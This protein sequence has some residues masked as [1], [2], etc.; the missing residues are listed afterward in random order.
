[1][2]MKEDIVT[3]DVSVNSTKR[4]PIVL[5]LDISPSMKINNRSQ[6]LNKAVGVLL[7]ELEKDKK[8][9][10][11]AEIAVVTFSTDVT[12]TSRFEPINYW[13]GK[14]FTPLEHGGTNLSSAVLKSIELIENRL[15][16]L[17]GHE[18][19][20]Y[21]PFIVLVTD[22]DPC[23]TDIPANQEKSINAVWQHCVGS[24]LIAPYIIGVGEQVNEAL[25]DRYAEKF[26]RKAI[27]LDDENQDADFKELFAFIGNSIKNSLKGEG[28]VGELYER[29]R[30]VVKKETGR[31]DE[32][33]KNR[34]H[35]RM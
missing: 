30:G 31:I 22:G 29:I 4:C 11:S 3:N 14:T 9:N 15:D 2:N 25:L 32:I 33:R 24:P 8:T 19:E 16:E 23:G 34:K 20:N 21:I 10:A 12:S 13:K 7:N 6:N 27:I 28:D 1:M 26:T 35:K 18:I 17:D 5:C